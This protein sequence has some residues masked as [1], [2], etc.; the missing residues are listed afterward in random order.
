MIE[1]PLGILLP[2]SALESTTF[3][4]FA[5]FVAF[6]TLLYV[7]LTL[8]KAVVWPDQGRLRQ[9]ATRFS[10]AT[11]GGGP[12]GPDPAGRPAGQERP[13]ASLRATFVAHD[14]PSAM[15]WFG[16]L[17]TALN[18]AF[19]FV[20]PDRDLMPRIAG[21]GL[22]VALLVAAQVLAPLAASERAASWMWVVSIATISAYLASPFGDPQLPL[23]LVVIAAS[24]FVLT[25]WAPFAVGG[26][27]GLA[28][29]SSAVWRTEPSDPAVWLLLAVAAFAVG[30]MILRTRLRGIETLE[31]ANRLSR[32]LATTDSLTG[33]LS[34][35]GLE[36]L[37]PRLLGTAQRAGELVC[38]M[39]IAIPDLDRAIADY[40]RNY[41][42]RV[43]EAVGSAVRTAVREGDMVARWRDD[44]FVV[45]GLGA[46]PAAGMLH[47][48]IQS[49]LDG[50]D[51]DLG[52]WPIL[53]TAGAASGDPAEPDVIA[54]LIERAAL[55]S[56]VHDRRPIVPNR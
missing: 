22:G 52:K 47:R 12:A 50:G 15:A 31:E 49:V 2:Q 32:L 13:A 19:I 21:V 3:R 54:G 48:R 1:F 26:A 25:A 9:L 23:L 5:G 38:V 30:A 27:L 46:E 56:R 17:L 18:V 20:G 35:S 6:N 39:H 16:V 24:G 33:A 40:G 8:A 51:I 10:P 41:G 36:S 11:R 4:V 37:L 42:D 34:R 55:T 28:A 45:V 43:V 44:S 7:G 14:I 29:T 53:V